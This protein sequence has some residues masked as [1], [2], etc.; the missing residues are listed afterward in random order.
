MIVRLE[1]ILLIAGALAMHPSAA[2]SVSSSMRGPLVSTLGSYPRDSTC[3]PSIVLRFYQRHVT[4]ADGD[5]CRMSPSCSMYAYEALSRYG[6][7]KGF[8]MTADRLTRCGNDLNSYEVIW[9][10]DIK[11]AVDPVLD[12]DI[13]R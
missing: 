1:S 3:T 8:R 5:R 9:V 12:D 13:M 10:N 2:L 6:F 7:I 11:F 4:I